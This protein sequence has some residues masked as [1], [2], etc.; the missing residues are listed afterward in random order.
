MSDKDLIELQN[1]E[2]NGEPL[3]NR[4]STKTLLAIYNWHTSEKEAAA[5]EARI[6]EVKK[7]INEYHEA[8]LEGKGRGYDFYFALRTRLDELTQPDKE[9]SDE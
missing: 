5:R 8:E 7:P 1:L 6:S 3:K 2:V 4:V 9:K